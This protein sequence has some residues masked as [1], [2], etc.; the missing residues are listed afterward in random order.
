MV[1]NRRINTYFEQAAESERRNE[2]ARTHR[3]NQAIGLVMLAAAILAW[4]LLHTNPAWIFPR[5][6]WRP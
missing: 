3:R 4:W 2:Q 5:G 6:W 1:L